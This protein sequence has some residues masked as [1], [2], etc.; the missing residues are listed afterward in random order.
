MNFLTVSDISR[1]L[2]VDRDAVAYAIR[3]AQ[4]EP[5][6]R[7]GLVKLFP[8]TTLDTVRAFI[9]KKEG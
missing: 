6:G 8:T 5:M 3:K 4:I 2:E 1:I 9:K 7:A